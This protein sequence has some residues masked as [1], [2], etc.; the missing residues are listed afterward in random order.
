MYELSTIY[1]AI[2]GA[3]AEWSWTTAFEDTVDGLPFIGLHRN[4]PR[5][6]FALGAGRHGAG[7]AW[8]AA[9]VLLRQFQGDPARGDEQL[10]FA[11]IL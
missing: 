10:G 8:L 2:S 6:L 4:F 7:T 1:P 3:R 5:Q 9:R 11:R